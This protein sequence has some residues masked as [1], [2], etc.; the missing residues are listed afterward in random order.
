M[1]RPG[2]ALPTEFILFTVRGC[3][4]GAVFATAALGWRC[5][6]CGSQREPHRQDQDLDIYSISEWK[7]KLVLEHYSFFYGWKQTNS[8]RRQAAKH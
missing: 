5:A 6:V 4:M 1:E 7:R 2:N 8:E 3:G